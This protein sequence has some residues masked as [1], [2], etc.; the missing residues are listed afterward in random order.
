MGDSSEKKINQYTFA[1]YNLENLFDTK[2]DP[3]KLDDD[4]IPDSKKKWSEKRLR[5]KIRDLGKV[6]QQIGYKDI[7]HPPVILGVAEVENAFVLNEL[8]ESEYLKNKGYDFVHFDSPDE[9]GIDTAMLY[10]KQYFTVTNSTAVT[11]NLINEQGVRDYT[12]DILHVTGNLENEKVHILINHWPSRRAGT[13]ETAYKRITAAEKN[14]E[15]ITK[16]LNNDADA[17]IIVMGDFNDNPQSESVKSLVGTFFYNPMEL[18]HTQ[19]S[20]SLSYKG[21]WNLFD[22]IILSNNFLQQHGNSFRFKKANIFDPDTLKEYKG[23]N[24][25]TPFRTFV[26]RKYIGGFSD[27][28]PVYGVFTSHPKSKLK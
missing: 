7:N 11:L 2:N 5:K 3:E 15:I 9:R 16:I 4:F 8:V 10:R 28:F 21:V 24:K 20:G 27:H 22:Q 17:K 18:L 13:Q 19:I 26:G 6:I 23:R 25:G 12:R 1:F 14:K